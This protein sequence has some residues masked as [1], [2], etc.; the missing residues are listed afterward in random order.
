MRPLD[1]EAT[2]SI[3]RYRRAFGMVSR[4]VD[5]FLDGIE[6]GKTVSLDIESIEKVIFIGIGGSGIIGDVAAQLLSAK[7]IKTEVLKNYNLP[8]DGWDLAIAIS[9]SGNT[10]ETIKPVLD[11]IDHNTPCIFITSDGLLGELGAK[12]GIPVARVKGGVPP[13]YGFPNMLGAALGILEKIGLMHVRI[14][15]E[16]LKKFQEKIMEGA[17]ADS[18]PAK[19]AAVRIA[20][21]NPIVYVYEEVKNVGYR[22]KCQLNENAKMYCGFGELPEALH[23]EVEA[24]SS[25]EL[26]VI[27]RIS[28]EGEEMK[29]TIE[30]LIRFLG[31]EKCLCLKAEAAKGLEELLELFML[32]D[33]ISLYVSI[34]RNADPVRLPR[35]TELRKINRINVEI[36]K[37]ARARI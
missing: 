10:A 4:F 17:V 1:S 12:K 18:N 34:L 7:G 37:R 8:E 6:S 13:R 32:M 15:P 29:E 27:P 22:L 33:Y 21:S 14:D 20:D 3:E 25:S 5:D 9:Y 23:N 19:Q 35:V 28:D 26:I 16:K 31:E 30:T 2:Y 11:L 36:L 24:I